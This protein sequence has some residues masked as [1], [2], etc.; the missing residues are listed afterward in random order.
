MGTWKP[1]YPRPEWSRG[2]VLG[3]LE[4]LDHPAGLEEIRRVARVPDASAAHALLQLEIRGVLVREP[5][6]VRQGFLWRIR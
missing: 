2:R 1:L 5:N 3:A 4:Q 6:P